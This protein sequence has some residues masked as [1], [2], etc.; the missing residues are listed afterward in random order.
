MIRAGPKGSSFSTSFLGLLATQLG[1][2]ALVAGAT[3]ARVWVGALMVGVS[4]FAFYFPVVLGA[5]LMGGWSTAVTAL[6]A[7]TLTA[8]LLFVGSLGLAIP[9]PASAVNLVAFVLGAGCAALA[10]VHVRRLIGELRAGN[11]RLAEGELRYRTLF[12][13]T[14]EGFALVQA[15]RDAAGALVDYR[16]L[17]ANPAILRMLGAPPSIVGRT[18]REV[19]PQVSEAYLAACDRALRGDPITF[20]FQSRASG[21]WYEVHLSHVTGD[22]LAQVVIDITDRKKADVRQAELFDELNHR[23][24]NN[25][26][27]VSSM[28]ALQARMGDGGR[29]REHLTKAVDRIQAIAEV[30]G[31]LYRTSRKDDVDFAAYLQDLCARLASS[32]LDGDR[33]RIEVSAEPAAMPLDRAVALGIVVN[34]LVTNAAKHAYPAPAEGLIE[35]RLEHAPPGLLL[36]VADDGLGLPA[37]LPTGGLGMR[38]VRSLV[39]QIG[40]TLEIERSPGAVFRIRL[41]DVA[42]QVATA[43]GQARLF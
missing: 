25:L 30:H 24:K 4:P 40:A 42:P 3:A 39:Q 41:A 15:I 1:T 13:A 16:I 38:L 35:V 14:S 5:A 6:V 17:E 29:V 9:D 21:A 12:Q 36:C 26:A 33:I 18:G 22:Q 7:S 34:E 20:E 10:G 19:F 8:W 31:S 32:L 43:T 23:V 28:L 27:M 2:L 11:A 37:D